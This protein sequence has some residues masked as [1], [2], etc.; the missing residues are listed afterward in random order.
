VACKK[1][2]PVVGAVIVKVAVVPETREPDPCVE[3]SSDKVTEPV[4]TDV[5]ENVEERVTVT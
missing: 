3:P 4:G 2:V 1:C 5:P